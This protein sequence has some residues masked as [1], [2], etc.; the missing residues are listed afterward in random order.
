MAIPTP[1]ARYAE[2]IADLASDMAQDG[3]D[4]EAKVIAM[5]A[6]NMR[7]KDPNTYSHGHYAFKAE[8]RAY[9]YQTAATIVVVEAQTLDEAERKARE[10]DDD[11]TIILTLLSFEKLDLPRHG[12]D[13]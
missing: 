5:V 3:H 6:R 4:T 9:G 7:A 1:P 2:R 10:P 12:T 13:A 8:G 11:P